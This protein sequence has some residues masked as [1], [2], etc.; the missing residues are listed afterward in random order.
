M[1]T[2]KTALENRKSDIALDIDAPGLGAFAITPTDA[3]ALT[4]GSNDVV[5]RA[6][7][8]GVSGDVAGK[9]LKRDSADSGTVIFKDMAIG[10]HEI[11][12]TQIHSTNTAATNIIG[13]Q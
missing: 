3:T 4:D 8:V 7:Y 9:V 5:V 13:L 2:G 10:I 12:F 1:A 11:A 6:I